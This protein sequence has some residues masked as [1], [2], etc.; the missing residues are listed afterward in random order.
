MAVS[1]WIYFFC[2]K[3]VLS[4]ETVMT[5]LEGAG[6]T[7]S[8][9]KSDNVA[10]PGIVVVDNASPK[11]TDFVGTLS[12]DGRRRILIVA[13]TSLQEDETWQLLKMGASDVLFWTELDDPA[14]R[15]AARLQRWVDIDRI[16]E[17]SLVQNNLVGQSRAWKSVVR[18]IVELA[19]FTDAPILLMG[20]TGTGKELV[21]RL[22]HTLDGKRNKKELVILDCSTIVPELSGTELFG[23][24]R[25]AFTGAFAARD[26]AFALADGGTLFLDE[27]GEL[28][29]DLQV[30]LLRVLQEHTYKRIGSSAWR[31]SDFRLVCA[32]NRDLQEE[33]A[34]GRF[35][36]DLYYR[37][38]SWVVRLP[39]LRERSTD[40][41]PLV[42][43]FMR[44]VWPSEQLL[45][46]DERVQAYLR[47]RDYQGNVRELQNLAFRIAAGHVG[48]G[49]VT[50][51]DIPLEDRPQLDIPDL[52]ENWCDKT[53]EQALRRAL[54]DG[55]K[56]KE[57]GRKV[58][59]VAIRITVDDENGN[60]QRSA[61]VLG[62]TDRT[63]QKWLARQRQVAPAM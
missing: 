43:H 45:E 36:R 50:L 26:G 21:A 29:L 57:I 44:Q 2:S 53:V 19:C 52:P 55:H 16:A 56:L 39:P 12:C 11:V 27:V 34:K 61:N 37:A 54:A 46:L 8:P 58:E 33:V 42:Y 47:A 28:S 59:E 41:I 4:R 1:A 48:P 20:E 38:A 22:I 60:L 51:G 5:S 7:I 63:L 13:M 25:G 3:S 24:E 31:K 14:S 32:T 10:G 6:V 23:H 49:P 9:L 15:I 17:S 18:H 40:I 30:Q 35:R 62:V